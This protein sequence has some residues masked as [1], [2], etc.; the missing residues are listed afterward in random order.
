MRFLGIAISLFVAAT[1]AMAQQSRIDGYDSARDEFFW[2]RLYAMGGVTIYCSHV[3]PSEQVHLNVG[4][5]RISNAG[6]RLSV[7]HAYPADWIA[8]ANGCPDRDHCGVPSYRFAEADLHNLWPAL[9][10][11][12]SSRSDLPL[13]TLP[14]EAE[15]RFEDICPD[16]ERSSG[17]N[18]R[19]EP[20]DS[21]KGDLARSQLYMMVSYDLP[22]HGSLDDLVEWHNADP[23]D[24]VERLRNNMI[25][26]MQGNRNPFIDYP[27]IVRILDLQ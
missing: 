20:Q 17:T 10:R 27:H 4:G 18:A 26:Q 23:P 11:I 2:P 14:G 22:L 16:F 24:D 5:H 3:F 1:S 7:E 12:N 21:V 8:E 9:G 13:G 25:E 6:E 19:I 15:R